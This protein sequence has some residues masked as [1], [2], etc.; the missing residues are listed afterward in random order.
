MK[1]KQKI[2][3]YRIIITAVM[4]VVLQFLPITGIPRLI[5]YL[6]AYLVIGYDILRKAG[7]G[8]LN[9]RAFDEN[10]LMALATL[11]A[12]FL[13][14][15]TKSGDYLEGIAVML[16][17]QIGE[18]FQSYAVGKSRKNISA[19]MDIRPDYANIE[20]DGK[21]EQVDPDEVAVGSIIVVQPGEKVPLDGVIL[22][23]TSSLNTS[24]LT[25]ESLPR[26]AKEGDEVISGCIN[27]T[28]VLRIQTTKEFGEST[29]SKILE[30]V[31]DSSS[32]KSKSEAFISKFARVYTPA[33]CYGA[34]AL[35]ILP[36]V[37]RLLT[38]NSAQ[39]GEWIYRALT[40]LVISCPCALVISIPLSFFAGIGGASK[41]GVL[42]KG[43]NYLETLSQVKTVVFDKTGTLTQGVFEVSGVHHNEMEDE[44]LLEYAALAECA[45]SHPISKSLQRAYG[46]EI[47]RDRVSDIQEISGKGISAKVDGHDVL[48]GNSKLM[49]LNRIAFIDRHSVGTIIHMAIDGEYAGHIVISDV[50]KPHAKEAIERLKHSGV[51]KTVMLTGDTRRVAEQVAKDLGVDEV[52]SDLLPADKVAQVEKLLAAKGDRDKLAFVGDGINDAP[53]LSRADIGIAMGAMGSDAA[54]EAADVVLMDDDPMKIA[55]AI[56]ISRKCIGIVYQNIVFA[57]VVKFACLALGALGIANMWVAIFADVGVMVLAVLNAIRALRVHDL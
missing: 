39:W 42:I 11:G 53:V 38:G 24:A 28:G 37:V 2:T 31:E 46:K 15:W 57:L 52:H 10:F 34:L 6:A 21:L 20:K 18:L 22:S 56:R 48:A 17:Y 16:F 8:I 29:V 3:L 50:V 36:P 54:I 33:V 7:K 13:A 12:F 49:E 47:D 5:A 44:K 14:I 25:G 32:H 19:L 40:F 23:G 43:S 1:K 27:M 26:D 55:K 9:G 4:L 51:E 30:L 35:A 41:E 45:S